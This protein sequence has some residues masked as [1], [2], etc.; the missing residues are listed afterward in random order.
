MTIIKKTGRIKNVDVEVETRRQNSQGAIALL[1]RLTVRCAGAVSMRLCYMN[2][3]CAEQLGKYVRR[4][5]R[6]NTEPKKTLVAGILQQLY[7]EKVYKL[8]SQKEGKNK[9]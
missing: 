5:N 2:I 6:E 1:K 3:K 7:L 4:Q 9:K 8:T